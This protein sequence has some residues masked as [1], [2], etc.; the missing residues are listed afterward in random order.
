VVPIRSREQHVAPFRMAVARALGAEGDGK[1]EIAL[2]DSEKTA[3]R[4]RLAQAFG[5]PFARYVA[6][7]PGASRRAK[8]WFPD[9]FAEVCRRV[10]GEPDTGV[11]FIAGPGEAEHVEHIVAMLDRPAPV[12]AFSVRELIATLA[13]CAAVVCLDSS[14]AHF[15]AAVGTPFVALYGGQTPALFGPASGVGV[16]LYKKTRKCQPCNHRGRCARECMQAITVDD[17][18]GALASVMRLRE[19]A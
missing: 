12:L 10:S 8:Q 7:H 13:A 2:A 15:A 5:R 19:T 6:I 16:C 17:V 9:R 1:P 4:E 3:A 18:M 11:F 14:A